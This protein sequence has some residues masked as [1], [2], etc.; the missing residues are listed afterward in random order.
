[1]RV[2]NA[3]VKSIEKWYPSQYSIVSTTQGLKALPNS[4]AADKT[5]SVLNK[6]ST[7]DT[8]S[9]KNSAPN[10]A[11]NKN[12]KPDEKNNAVSQAKSQT[13]AEFL[14]SLHKTQME[15]E[16]FNMEGD[17]G[18]ASGLENESD[19]KEDDAPEPMEDEKK[20]PPVHVTMVTEV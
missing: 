9:N 11:L 3:L 14:R 7:P 16:M 19:L 1:M 4:T 8:A 17:S 18:I 6:N 10:T 15:S 13:L 12:S 5:K 20:P 2:L